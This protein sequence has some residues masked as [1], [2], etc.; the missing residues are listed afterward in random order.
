[1]SQSGA[2]A[3]HSRA[4]ASLEAAG[5]I[6]IPYAEAIGRLTRFLATALTPCSSSIH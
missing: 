6:G 3:P 4:N 1:M 2:S 5:A